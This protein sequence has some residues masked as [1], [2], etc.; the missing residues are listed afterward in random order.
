M[1]RSWGAQF[2]SFATA[3]RWRDHDYRACFAADIVA[4]AIDF[5][6]VRAPVGSMDIRCFA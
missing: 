2:R 4:A 6:L 5:V 3:Y 1:E